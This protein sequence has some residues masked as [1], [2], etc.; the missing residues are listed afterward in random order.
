MCWPRYACP[1][2]DKYQ[3]W[4]ASSHGD[5]EI[6]RPQKW[7]IQ[8]CAEEPAEGVVRSIPNYIQ[9]LSALLKVYPKLSSYKGSHMCE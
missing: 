8:C 1:E 7:G 2:C 5:R 6:L 3:H 9:G 4:V